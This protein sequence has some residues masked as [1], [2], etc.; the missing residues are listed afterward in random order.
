MEVIVDAP[1]GRLEG[2]MRG[3]LAQFFSIPYA[4]PNVGSKRFLPPKP[5]PRWEG[6]RPSAVPGPAAP[7]ARKRGLPTGGMDEDCLTLSVT[8]PDVHGCA[9]VLLWVHG[10]AFQYGWGSLGFRPEVFARAGIV[11][12]SCQYR[13]GVLGFLDVSSWLGEAYR[14][15]G[16]NGLL[17][18]RQALRWIQDNIAAFGGDPGQVTIMG[19]SAGARICAALT[20]MDGAK[21]LFHRAVLASGAA[22][23]LRDQI[24]ARCVSEGFLHAAGLMDTP[25]ALLRMP[26]AEIV[27]QQEAFFTAEKLAWLG[28][29]LD[30][31][32]FPEEDA[33]TLARRGGAGADILMG[34]NRDEMEW[35]W[36]SWQCRELNRPLAET[37]FGS[38]ASLVMAHY[39]RMIR[40]GDVHEK[41]IHFLTEYLFRAGVVRLAE[42]ASAAGQRVYLYRLDWDRQSLRACHGSETQFFMGFG[43]VI[44]DV[45]RSA[46]HEALAEKMRGAL[47]SFIKKGIPA[48]EGLPEWPPFGEARRMMRFDDPCEVIDTPPMETDPRMPQQVFGLDG[49]GAGI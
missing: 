34:T 17:D 11:A 25:E 5:R 44:P 43:L 41:T 13:L 6:V 46:A 28:P 7:Q 1:C 47:L 32:T 21:G 14:Q 10:G 30:G 26:W 45:D 36:R 12:V 9:P 15:S 49:G 24:T 35:F 29:V 38:R 48:A 20:L 3:G 42:A 22:D 37:L 23:S 2:R 39:E 27:K 16:N 33:L 8:T 31:V 19:Q 4:A 18:V 40:G